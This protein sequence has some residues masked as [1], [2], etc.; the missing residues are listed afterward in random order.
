[1]S[2]I[3]LRFKGGVA[4]QTLVGVVQHGDE[5]AV[6][7][8]IGKEMLGTG[9]YEEVSSKAKSESKKEE[10]KEEKGAK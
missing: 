5:I 2:E 8:S 6:P 7:E 9:L 1:M 4:L 10:T 3:K